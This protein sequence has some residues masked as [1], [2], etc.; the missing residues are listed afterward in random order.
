MKCEDFVYDEE[1][2]SLSEDGTCIKSKNNVEKR[3]QEFFASFAIQFIIS[4]NLHLKLQKQSRQRKQQI[5]LGACV[6]LN[7]CVGVCEK[8]D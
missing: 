6:I 2:K 5:T 1:K 3:C 8:R 4:T 7:M